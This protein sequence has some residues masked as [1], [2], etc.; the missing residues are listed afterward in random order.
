MRGAQHYKHETPPP[1]STLVWST[2]A[3][4]TSFLAMLIVG[5]IDKYGAAIKNNHLPFAIAPAGAASVL[6]F[7]IPSSPFGQPRNVIVGNMI[8]ALV[9]T[10]MREL[11]KHTSHS[12]N[13]MPGAL[14]VG[15]STGLMGITNCYHPPAGAAAFIAGNSESAFKR[16][17]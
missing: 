9:G 10:F 4:F 16:V 14:A 11:F 13:W 1:P 17:G 3:G 12:F 7:G 6:I 15:I 8:S 2:Y 5:V